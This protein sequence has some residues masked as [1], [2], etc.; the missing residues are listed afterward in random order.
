MNFTASSFVLNIT[1]RTIFKNVQLVTR[2]DLIESFLLSK[3]IIATI[4]NKYTHYK[5]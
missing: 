5:F 2:Y 3:L 1:R 4:I